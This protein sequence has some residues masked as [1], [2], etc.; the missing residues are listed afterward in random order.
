VSERLKYVYHEGDR[1]QLFDLQRDPDELVNRA[2]DPACGAV[3][4][5]L[6]QALRQW[7]AETGDFIALR[8]S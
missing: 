6:R 2:D 3:V 8:E 1:D 4:S 7:M 5:E